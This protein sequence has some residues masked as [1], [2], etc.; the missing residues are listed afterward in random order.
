MNAALPLYPGGESFDQP[1]PGISEACVHLASCACGDWIVWARPSR[2]LVCAIRRAVANE[3]L[4]AL[5]KGQAIGKAR[6]CAFLIVALNRNLLDGSVHPFFGPRISLCLMLFASESVSSTWARLRAAELC[7]EV[8]YSLRHKAARRGSFGSLRFSIKLFPKDLKI[9]PIAGLSTAAIG[10]EHRLV[11]EGP[12]NDPPDRRR[13]WL[14]NRNGAPAILFSQ[15][16][17]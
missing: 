11:A 13:G 10:P 7:A 12:A 16:L 4:K 5:K 9:I 17:G 15:N 2:C 3:G 1:A 14:P 8:V 6:M